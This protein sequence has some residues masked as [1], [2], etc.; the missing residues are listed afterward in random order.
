MNKPIFLRV[1]KG[2]K[3]VEMKQVTGDQIVIGR[4]GDVTLAVHDESAAAI[5]AMIENRSGVYFL[6]D[7]GTENGTL[8]SGKKIVEVELKS[9]DEFVIGKTTVEFHIGI[10]KPVAS[11]ATSANVIPSVPSQEPLNDA[12]MVERPVK[13]PT[14]FQNPVK[15]STPV[16]PIKSVE[17]KAMPTP[18]PAKPKGQPMQAAVKMTGVASI[19]GGTSGILATSAGISRA[20]SKGTFAPPTA[21]KVG[22]TL[23]PGRGNVVQLIV[24]WKDRVLTEHHFSTTKVVYVGSH[25]KNDIILPI[26][27][28]VRLSHPLIK[29]EASITKLILTSDMTGELTKKDQSKKTFAEMKSSGE[30]QTVGT[31]YVYVLK[32]DEMAKI[33]F[34][35]GV[36]LVIS[37]VASPGSAVAGPLFNIS[38][39][40]LTWLL[41]SLLAT[42]LFLFYVFLYA[43]GPEDR[44]EEETI[45]PR[46]ATFMYKKHVEDVSVQEVSPAPKTA[47]ETIKT[48]KPVATSNIE[49]GAAQEAKPNKSK[50][51]KKILTADKAG[52]DKGIQKAANHAK[53]SGA[54]S[55]AK[56]VTKSG[57]LGVFAT[58]GVQDQINKAY[59]GSGNV[60]GAASGATGAGSEVAGAGNIPGSGMKEVGQGGNGTATVGIAGPQT[61]GRGGGLTGY[62]SGPLGGKKNA[63]IIAGGDDMVASGGIDKEAIR[64]VVLANIKQI[65]ACYE[66]GLNRDPSLYGKITIQWTI[67]SGGRVLSAGVRNT[68][69]NNSEVEDCAVARLKTWKFPEPPANEVADVS[70]PFVFQ[71]QD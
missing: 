38:I 62:G 52:K 29:I 65:K 50:S 45:S 22:P 66:K 61:K 43:P 39:N 71:A 27:G 3:A 25:P 44:K 54:K 21:S 58:K 30:I 48:N 17:P 19:G 33:H 6:C 4:E 36:E 42:V 70:Y 51:G 47:Q 28:S 60:S 49:E 46:K 69:M 7:L 57:I 24:L 53:D 14:P 37:Y 10:P 16:V 41:V 55:A 23:K 12:P 32:Q 63:S 34:G 9:G 5:H 31:N 56:D 20:P 64:R 68:T 13:K 1:V 59:Q 67:G 8:I 18:P 2:G 35:E 11:T 40:Q 26:F 15:I